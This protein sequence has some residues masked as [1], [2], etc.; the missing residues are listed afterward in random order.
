MPSLRLN[1]AQAPGRDS[2]TLEAKRPLAFKGRHE[3]GRKPFLEGKSGDSFSHKA[4]KW[5]RRAMRIDRENNRY[6]ETVVDPSR[7]E[8]I[9]KCEEPFSDH[10]GHGSAKKNA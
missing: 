2:G 9:H 10:R 1:V 4:Q 6:S 5:V 8:I 7:Q 3:S